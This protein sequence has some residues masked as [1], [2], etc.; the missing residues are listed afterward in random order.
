MRWVLISKSNV[1]RTS[2][3]K[4]TTWHPHHGR[5]V[6]RV[7]AWRAS[8]AGNSEYSRAGRHTAWGSD[9][10][11][12]GAGAVR[13]RRA[14]GGRIQHGHRRGRGPIKF[15]G[16]RSGE[17]SSG[18]GDYLPKCAAGR[19]EGG[20]GSAGN[21]KHSRAARRTTGSGDRNRS[22]AGAVR[23][24]R[25]YGA[26]VQHGHR[27]GRGPIKFY[28]RRSGE[29]RSGEG[30]YLPNIT[31]GGREGRDGRRRDWQDESTP[32]PGEDAAATERAAEDVAGGF[33]PRPAPY[34]VVGTHLWTSGVCYG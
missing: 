31:A 13:H 26:R 19:R 9:R 25:A 4:S 7:S 23:H 32:E 20:D 21:S 15:H 29:V 11:R 14:N 17:V 6:I 12:S 3:G 22:A 33:V 27:G 10:N 30:D 18:E 8:G 34:H 16:R 2:H 24:R 28:G 5:S 1:V